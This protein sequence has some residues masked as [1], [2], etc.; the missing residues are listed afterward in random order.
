[1]TFQQI[2]LSKIE[3]HINKNHQEA[4]QSLIEILRDAPNNYLALILK[5]K[6]KCLKSS[7]LLKYGEIVNCIS[8]FQDSKPFS[9]IF[10]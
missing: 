7:L 4:L 3:E 8:D 5:A 9:G 6:C 10:S 1:M 2:P